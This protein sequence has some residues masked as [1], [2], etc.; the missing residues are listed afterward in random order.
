MKA[1]PAGEQ[2]LTRIGIL[3]CAA[4][5]LGASFALWVATRA[6]HPSGSW[7][8]AML[9]HHRDRA[10]VVIKDLD[11]IVRV[12]I[13]RDRGVEWQA[14]GMVS[15]ASIDLRVL[16]GMEVQGALDRRRDSR[17]LSRFTRELRA[18]LQ[19]EGRAVPTTI[20]GP[21]PYSVRLYLVDGSYYECSLALSDDGDFLAIQARRAPMGSSF[22]GP[23]PSGSGG[24]TTVGIACQATGRFR[25]MFLESLSP[26]ARSKILRR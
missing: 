25:A 17:A 14:D 22:Q 12:E 13:R 16:G 23:P 9:Q 20:G 3:L 18:M 5:A 7:R 11:R 8:E 26:D 19:D 21:V 6:T 24:D 15:P 10:E 1:M 2:G 4:A